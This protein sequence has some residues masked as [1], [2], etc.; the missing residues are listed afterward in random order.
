MASLNESIAKAVNEGKDSANRGMHVSDVYKRSG[1][2]INF[3]LYGNLETL[4]GIWFSVYNQL[5]R[6]S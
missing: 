5:H 4:M 2:E 6:E 1:D 3:L